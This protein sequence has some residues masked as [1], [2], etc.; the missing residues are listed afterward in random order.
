MN[1]IILSP[2]DFIEKDKRVRLT[3]TRLKHI[4][5]VLKSSV[6]DDLCVGELNG[7]IGTGTIV[8]LE[9]KFVDLEVNL[10]SD[11]PKPH[12]AMLIMALPRPI[13][14]KRILA[15]VS[16]LGVKKIY[17]IHSQRV[18][19]SYWKSPVLSE[20]QMT[21]QLILGLE[22]AKDTILPKVFLRKRFKPFIED[23]LPSLIK[24]SQA[25][26]GHP[27]AEN[28]FPKRF[29]KSVTLFVGPEG[30][31]IDYEIDLL[32]KQGVAP[33]SLG[34]RVLRVETAIPV[35]LAKIF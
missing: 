21:E 35:L 15:A 23:E 33:V 4:Q 11:P 34:P 31:F 22:Q 2:K 25:I 6:K 27:L 28:P 14:L 24:E 9:K 26:V 20:A 8:T 13:V 7:K 10:F 19:K 18:E 17:L 30:G 5:E 32:R 12:P 1:L 16:S 3:S 29:H